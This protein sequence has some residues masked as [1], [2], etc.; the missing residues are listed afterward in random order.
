MLLT[1]E[2]FTTPPYDADCWHHN[3]D[4]THYLVW[5]AI[6]DDDKR[7]LVL[8]EARA[9]GVAIDGHKARRALLE[10]R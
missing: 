4:G 6:D 9:L 7:L 3:A 2:D 1:L 8:I 5:P 10:N